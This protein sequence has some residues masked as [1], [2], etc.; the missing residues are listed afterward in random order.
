VRDVIDGPLLLSAAATTTTATAA[1]AAAAA[2]TTTTAAAAT[3]AAATTTKTTT[4]TGTDKGLLTSHE[5]DII[6][7]TCNV[8][9]SNEDLP[10]DRFLSRF[11]FLQAIVRLAMKRYA[12]ATEVV[13]GGSSISVRDSIARLLNEW[14]VCV[15]VV[16]VVVARFRV[17]PSNTKM[18][19]WVC[20]FCHSF[21][22]F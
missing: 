22:Y 21:W 12:W 6:F 5:A 11:E 16:V 4:T 7:I 2:T 18:W 8:K 9:L 20:V 3:A 1:T 19:L 14:V 13:G 15:V 10:P 17:V